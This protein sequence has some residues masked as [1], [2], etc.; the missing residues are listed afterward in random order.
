M[1][2]VDHLNVFYGEFQALSDIVFEVRREQIVSLLGAN[3]AGKSTLLKT[4]MGIRRPASGAIRFEN[5]PIDR[6]ESHDIVARGVALVPEGRKIFSALTVRENLL[7]GS[8]TP[9]ARRMRNENFESVLYLFPPLR[10]RLQH[11]GTKLSGGEQQM[12]AIGR[13]LM[14]QPSFIIFDEISLGLSPIVIKDLY[15]AIKEINR[16]GMTGVIVEQDVKRSLKVAD[17]AYILHEGRITLQG[18]PGSFTEGAVKRAYF[19]L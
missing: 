8:Y 19:G 15:K 1:L 18:D 14:S 17:Y 10:A 3:S 4:I 5:K 9:R 12:L 16:K 2:E 11:K 6:L 13:A 7:L